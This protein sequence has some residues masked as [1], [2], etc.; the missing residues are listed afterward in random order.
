MIKSI[1]LDFMGTLYDPNSNRLYSD[2]LPILEFLKNDYYL[3]LITNLKEDKRKLI[4]NLGLKKY[5]NQIIISKKNKELIADIMIK[6]QNKKSEYLIIG[7]DEKDEIEL[8]R[9][10]K[11]KYLLIDRT[12]NPP[13]KANSINSL[14]ELKP[15]LEHYQQGRNSK[16]VGVIDKKIVILS[17]DS[18]NF[19]IEV[20]LKT[21]L[22]R[23]N[24]LSTKAFCKIIHN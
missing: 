5:F 12:I 3:I 10:L 1:I 2:T 18:R 22:V 9:K 6:N 14:R 13:L 15:Y 24:H 7:N 16:N 4:E 23:S 17:D 19:K 20:Y 21:V 11:L 8:A